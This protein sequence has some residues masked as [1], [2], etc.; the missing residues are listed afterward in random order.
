MKVRPLADRSARRAT[1]LARVWVSN[2]LRLATVAEK[3]ADFCGF[4]GA[5][6]IED[7]NDTALAE[8][9]NEL[10]KWWISAVFR[11]MLEMVERS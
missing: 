7:D 5:S 1:R 10:Q 8:P 3:T 4:A 9:L 11:S 6:V 2:G